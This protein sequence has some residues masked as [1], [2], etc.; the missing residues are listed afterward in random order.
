MKTGFRFF[1][2]AISEQ[3]CRNRASLSQSSVSECVRFISKVHLN[4]FF[5]NQAP[6]TDDEALIDEINE[7]EPWWLEKSHL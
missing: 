4:L 2:P 1:I 6:K 5:H 3:L 7:P